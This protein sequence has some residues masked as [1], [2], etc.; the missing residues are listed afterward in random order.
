Q[1]P[2][3]C[4][5]TCNLGLNQVS[6]ATVPNYRYIL[7]Y[8]IQYSKVNDVF[9]Q[10]QL[11]LSLI[12]RGFQG[13]QMFSQKLATSV[14]KKFGIT[15]KLSCV[16]TWH[17]L[18]FVRNLIWASLTETRLWPAPLHHFPQHPVRVQQLKLHRGTLQGELRLWHYVKLLT[19]AYIQ[20]LL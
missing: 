9:I 4:I 8:N 19:T 15:I 2:P 5:K 17:F 14:S 7:I 11:P 12:Q 6:V 10:N 13:E 20:V 1:R 16:M 3:S 18:N